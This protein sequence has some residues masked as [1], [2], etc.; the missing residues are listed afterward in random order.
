MARGQSLRL[1]ALRRRVRQ[2]PPPATRT[3]AMNRQADVARSLYLELRT[4]PLEV[5]IEVD[6]RG[7]GGVLYYGIAVDDSHSLSVA[8]VDSVTRRILDNG[9]D[10]V[11]LLV[12]ERDLDLRALP[13]KATV[14]NEGSAACVRNLI[15]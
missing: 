2:S 7:A 13:R 6:T 11:R 10:I 4:L 12:N 9:N 8:E 15:K 14:G 1:P 3:E 5:R